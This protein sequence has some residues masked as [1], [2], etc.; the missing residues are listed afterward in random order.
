TAENARA[1]L[2]AGALAVSAGTGVVPPDA[3]AAADWGRI[4]DAA[5][6]FRASTG[7]DSRTTPR[8]RGER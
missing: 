6:A 1:F 5:R 3:V 7:A 2:D 8:D 4:T